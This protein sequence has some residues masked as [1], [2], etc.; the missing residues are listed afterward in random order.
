MT[1]Q[2]LYSVELTDDGR[3]TIRVLG[4]AETKVVTFGPLKLFRVAPS[5]RS[6]ESQSKVQAKREYC[7]VVYGTWIIVG[8]IVAEIVINVV[9][10]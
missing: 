4:K 9:V 5:G 7:A 6:G 3:T 8:L 2:P 1:E 10:K